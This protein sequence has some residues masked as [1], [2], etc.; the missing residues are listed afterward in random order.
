[1]PVVQIGRRSSVQSETCK[2]LMHMPIS[3][4]QSHGKEKYAKTARCQVE[5]DKETNEET[6]EEIDEKTDP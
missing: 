4:T 1:M 5:T 6:N 3:K 2:K